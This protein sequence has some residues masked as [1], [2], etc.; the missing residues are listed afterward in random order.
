MDLL[1]F[2]YPSHLFYSWLELSWQV[3]KWSSSGFECCVV[4]LP[5]VVWRCSHL[6]TPCCQSRA[7]CLHLCSRSISV[8]YCCCTQLC[9]MPSHPPTH[10]NL[11]TSIVCPVWWH[12]RRILAFIWT[13]LAENVGA[14]L[15]SEKRQYAKWHHSFEIGWFTLQRDRILNLY[16]N[17]C[18]K[19]HDSLYY[20]RSWSN[21][22]DTNWTKRFGNF[23]VLSR[24]V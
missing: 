14:R 4:G 6:V 19:I 2:F 13:I 8:T 21:I 12:H 11:F 1:L 20:W 24:T 15:C 5:T 10:M 17:L 16:W 3:V 18:K 22:Q 7:C 23:K 9:P